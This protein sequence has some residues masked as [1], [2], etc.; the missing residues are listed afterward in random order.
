MLYKNEDTIAAIST[1]FGSGGIGIIRISGDKAF[2]IAEK[3]FRGKKKIKDMKS[4]T[5]NYGKIIDPSDNSVIDEVLLSKMN[6]PYTYTREDVVEINC[7]SG[8]VVLKKILE[9]LIK[10]GARLA[11]PGEFT[12]RAFLNGRIDLSQAEA[13][14][15]I[16]NAKTFKSSKVAL[17]QLEGRLSHKIK[18]IRNE[19]IELIAKIEVT[20]DYPEEDVYKIQE[21]EVYFSLKKLKIKLKELLESFDKGKILREGI[22]IVIA[23]RP[24][25]GKSSLLNELTGYNRAIVTE[26]PGTTRD[27]IEEYINI[28]GI[29]VRLIDTA[30]IRETRDVVEKIGVGLTKEAINKADLVIMMLDYSEGLTDEDI[31]ILKTI[32]EKKKIILI[33]KIDLAENTDKYDTDDSIDSEID[34]KLMELLELNIPNST[35][36]IKTS[37]IKGIGLNELEEE[38]A[39]MFL[40][41]EIESTADAMVTNIRHAE[42]IQKTLENIEYAI[43]AYENQIPLDC[44]TVD[45]RNAVYHLGEITG[46]SVSEEIINEIFSRFCLGK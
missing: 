9:L 28:N 1:P 3:V 10:T 45:I 21:E 27:I 17:Q 30:G 39:R 42:L 18:E 20:L 23:G 29:P 15:D 40:G 36:I 37:M 34:S 41:G 16:I 13:V 25:V 32:R 26:I 4:H 2:E 43:S 5:I 44:M 38:I 6:K 24:N 35:R 22:S 7:H 11:E 19:L 31:E 14:M 33:N 8:P 12:K 46:E